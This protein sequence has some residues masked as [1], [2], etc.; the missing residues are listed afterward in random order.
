MSA[1]E[2]FP[3]RSSFANAAKLGPLSTCFPFRPFLEFLSAFAT[4]REFLEEVF[5]DFEAAFALRFPAIADSWGRRVAITKTIKNG[6]KDLNSCFIYYPF[7][8]VVRGLTG[9]M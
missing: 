9:E 8:V 7:P 3:L 1:F 6:A 4:W 5:D 2:S